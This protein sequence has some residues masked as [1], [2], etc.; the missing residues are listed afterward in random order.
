MESSNYAAGQYT[1]NICKK[2]MR[3]SVSKVLGT[4]SLWLALNA[5]VPSGI[6][7]CGGGGG[8]NTPVWISPAG[9]V[10]ARIRVMTATMLRCL[11]R[12]I[13]VSRNAK[14]MNYRTCECSTLDVAE[15][16]LEGE[17]YHSCLKLEYLQQAKI[18]L[19]VLRELSR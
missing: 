1:G 16:K 19:Q 14:V 17:S 10:K 7:D 12:F 6:G 8:G 15:N 11:I 9:V 4:K 5:L 13:V 18:F 2:I 3:I